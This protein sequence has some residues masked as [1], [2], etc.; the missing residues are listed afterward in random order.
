M[1]ETTT[2]ER[3]AD[4]LLPSH[5]K[6]T[7]HVNDTEI[8]EYDEPYESEW[9]DEHGL[10]PPYDFD[11]NN[12]K[13]G[14]T[15]INGKT[16][17]N[18]YS[19]GSDF[20]IYSL[21]NST[22]PSWKW[23]CQSSIVDDGLHKLSLLLTT[24]DNKFKGVKFAGLD[25]LVTASLRVI[26]LSRDEGRIE[27]A[28]LSFEEAI[29]NQPAVRS[30]IARSANFAVWIS[31]RGNVGFQ[32]QNLDVTESINEYTRIKALATSMLPQ[33]HMET[34]NYR[35]GAALAN[36]L[37]TKPGSNTSEFFSPLETL[38]HR[39]AENKLRISYLFS[40]TL[41]TA[42]LATAFFTIYI[43][44]TPSDF[45]KSSLVV[46]CGGFLGTFISVLERSNGITISE[47]ESPK[48]IILQGLLRVCLG[49]IFGLTAYL[50]A[51]SGFAFS[52]FSDMTAK[53]L[54]LGIIAGFSERL[55]PDLIHGISSENKN[56][57][58]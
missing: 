11:I 6:N 19:K 55:I 30:V 42:I 31:E 54:L 5:E 8:E 10:T 24:A 37:R 33:E 9:D 57:P 23:T 45:F 32:Y 47:Y 41:T 48:L 29:K 28:L 26:F 22:F 13:E 14:V 49:G 43:V 16:V 56:S 7:D 53:L 27:K 50:A 17:T 40:T 15:L 35:L 4:T 1:S 51:I 44:A 25:A 46:A 18:V 12:I 58:K 21:N 20:V 34:F 39:I 3:I 36:A 2:D 52:I 38:I